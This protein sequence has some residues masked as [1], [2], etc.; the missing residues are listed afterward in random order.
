MLMSED[1]GEEV[2]LNDP[3]VTN[4][5][6]IAS[7]LHHNYLPPPL[8]TRAIRIDTLARYHRHRC[9]LT[10]SCLFQIQTQ[11]LHRAKDSDG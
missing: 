7:P 1:D 6:N 10:Q 11:F 5:K 3:L 8:S 2:T 4:R 9:R